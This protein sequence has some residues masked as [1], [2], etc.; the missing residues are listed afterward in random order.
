MRVFVSRPLVLSTWLQWVLIV[1][2]LG[3]Q[4][5]VKALI[6]SLETPWLS[7]LR[8]LFFYIKPPEDP[9]RS[10]RPLS[11]PCRHL[12]LTTLEPDTGST[13]EQS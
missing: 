3:G 6:S 4:I 10:P 9:L 11:R 8:A 2:N 13:T 1:L 5:R 7:S 12:R